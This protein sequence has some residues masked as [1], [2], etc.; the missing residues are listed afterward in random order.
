MDEPRKACTKCYEV[1][2]ATTEYFHRDSSIN[3]PLGYAKGNVVL[4][5]NFANRGRGNLP[6][7]EFRTF[8]KEI[9]DGQTQAQAVGTST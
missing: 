2:P 8:L 3:P 6:A 9:K 1:K 5:C 7:D 4:A